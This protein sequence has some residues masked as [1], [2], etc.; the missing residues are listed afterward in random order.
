MTQSYAEILDMA[1]SIP[2]DKM[3]TAE[4]LKALE[5]IWDD[6]CQ[7]DSDIPVPDWHLELLR[8]REE[9]VAR[10]EERPIDWE[11]AKKLIRDWPRCK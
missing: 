1:I 2:L 8:E 4:K 7:N 6:L 11:D 9:A 3:T 10:G 5:L